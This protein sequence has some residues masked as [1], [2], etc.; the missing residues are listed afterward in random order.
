MTRW[1][2]RRLSVTEVDAAKNAE[3]T[4]SWSF[5]AELT[6]LLDLGTQEASVFEDGIVK[7]PAGEAQG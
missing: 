5:G 1:V 4:V 2:G 6:A 7:Y 3:T